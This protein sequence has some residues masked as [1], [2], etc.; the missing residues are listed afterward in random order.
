LNYKSESI[1]NSGLSKN[2][3]FKELVISNLNFSYDKTSKLILSNIN[4]SIKKGDVI[5]L[6]GESGVG[7]STLVDLL[8]GIN[9][10][11]TGSLIFNDKDIFDPDTRWNRQVGYIQQNVFL[12]DESLVANIALGIAPEDVDYEKLKEV[13]E[14]SQLTSFVDNLPEGLNS[15]VGERGLRISGGQRQRIGIARALYRN[16]NFLV[17]DEAT[18]NLDLKTEEAIIGSIKNLSLFKTIVIIAHRK[19]ALSFCNK[20]YKVEC[21]NLILETG[22]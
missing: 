9:K 16:P 1:N 20:I 18:S 10:P 21:G 14:Q 5:G 3:E 17:F 12:S 6:I 13:I 4:L 22:K 19:S 7:K 15:D 8:L 11:N 2:E